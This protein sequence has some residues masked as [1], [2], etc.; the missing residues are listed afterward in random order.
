VLDA[1]RAFLAD[2][3]LARAG[4]IALGVLVVAGGLAL[5]G[6]TWWQSQQAQG[7]VA[8]AAA[9]ELAQTAQAPGASP[10]ARAAASQ[11]LEAVIA[12]HP[13]YAGLPQ[14]AYRLGNLRY[15]A[16]EYAAARGAYQVAL[17][18]GA[19]GT[20][21]TL[22]GVGIGYTWEAEKDYTKAQ[23]AYEAA[24]AGLGPKDFLYEAILLDLARV[25]EFG[26]R[27]EAALETYRRLLKDV[28]ESRR[29]D[30]VRT[31][32]ASLQSAP[33]KP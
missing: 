28:P 1:L 18:Q 15:A 7:A 12:Q 27:R 5:G 6:W 33:A 32:I 4:L 10:A 2:S 13:R 19:M 8:L 11:A 20:V 3:R 16:G 26:G 31:R 14:A 24:L 23:T 17:A 29:A 9:V 30:D 25:Q 21:R 22:A